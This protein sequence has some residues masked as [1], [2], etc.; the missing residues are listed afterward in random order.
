MGQSWVVFVGSWLH[1]SFCS[2]GMNPDAAEC[3]QVEML[4]HR[5]TTQRYIPEDDNIQD[6]R[7][8][9]SR[10]MIVGSQSES[11][12]PNPQLGLCADFYTHKQMPP[13]IPNTQQGYMWLKARTKL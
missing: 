13:P 5:R 2:W 4:G 11:S 9:W 12:E 7:I 6:L 1:D 3:L 10:V 8:W